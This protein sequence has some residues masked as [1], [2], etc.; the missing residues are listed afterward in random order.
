MLSVE[1]YI[2]VDIFRGSYNGDRF[3][4]FVFYYILLKMNLWL[5]PRSV[6]IVDNYNMYNEEVISARWDD[7]FCESWR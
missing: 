7:F 6:F 1:G 3:K 5:L 2:A 4:S